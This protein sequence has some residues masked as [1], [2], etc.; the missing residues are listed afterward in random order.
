MPGNLLFIIGGWAIPNGL[1]AVAD[2]VSESRPCSR[3]QTIGSQQ[4]AKISCRGRI[5]LGTVDRPGAAAPTGRIATRGRAEPQRAISVSK[6]REVGSGDLPLVVQAFGDSSGFAELRESRKAQGSKQRHDEDRDEHFDECNRADGT[7]AAAQGSGSGGGHNERS[8]GDEATDRCG[9]RIHTQNVFIDFKTL[10]P[11][12]L[13][14]RKFP[15]LHA[16]FLASLCVRT[17]QCL[18]I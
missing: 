8:S 7:K 15:S 18:W 10:Q 5:R 11:K 14:K 16:R 2:R 6:I 13:T 4:G 1:A 17:F 12:I 9:G 3:L